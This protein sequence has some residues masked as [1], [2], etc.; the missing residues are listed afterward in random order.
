M[1]VARGVPCRHGNTACIT[2]RGVGTDLTRSANPYAGAG[3]VSGDLGVH[4]PRLTGA[5]PHVT[6]TAAP[7]LPAFLPPTF[8]RPAT[9]R[10]ATSPSASSTSRRTTGA[11]WPDANAETCG[12]RRGGGGEQARTGRPLPSVLRGR[13]AHAVAPSRHGDSPDQAGGDRVAM[14][15]APG[16]GLRR[17]D[18]GAMAHRGPQRDLRSTGASAGGAL[19]GVVSL[20]QA[21]DAAEDGRGGWGAMEC[22]DHQPIG[23]GD[24]KGG[25]GACRGGLYLCASARGGPP[26]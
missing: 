7:N 19:Y 24:D 22:G 11:P 3:S 20:L 16:L 12:R 23:T 10:T 8:E 14:A 18:A 5:G 13:G 1:T 26:C 4:G 6:G 2:A 17:G 15:S 25:R 9:A 21:P